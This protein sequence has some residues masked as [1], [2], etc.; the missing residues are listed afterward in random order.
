MIYG[1]IKDNFLTHLFIPHDL[2]AERGIL[3]PGKVEPAERRGRAL[4]VLE[5]VDDVGAQDG[6]QHDT[7]RYRAR[8]DR[9]NVGPPAGKVDIAVAPVVRDDGHENA[10]QGEQPDHG[11]KGYKIHM[12]VSLQSRERVSKVG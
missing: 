2:L 12:V 6:S 10:Q 8:V 7:D 9:A 1:T 5:Y 4:R 3:T 11:T